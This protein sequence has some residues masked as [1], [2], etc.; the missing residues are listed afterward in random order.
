MSIE[1]R[2]ALNDAERREVYR[3][4]H[5]VYADEGYCE[6]KPGGELRH[7]PYLD[8]IPETT[9][10]IAT[11]R[12]LVVGTVSVTLDGPAGL[13]TDEDFP[14]EMREIRGYCERFG[15]RLAS[16]WRIVTD[17]LYRGRRSLVN[18]LI[19]ETFRTALRLCVDLLV[20]DF[21][22]KHERFYRR[23]VGF[24][25][26]AFANCRAVGNRPAVLMTYDV[27]V[28]KVPRRW[29]TKPC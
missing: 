18:R 17:P 23:V 8:E 26:V 27:D 10:L 15:R 2:E 24:D 7:Y 11:E 29:R 20:C 1:V 9:I 16:S 5:R 13:H 4:T 25:T 6:L 14:R 22:P 12:S 28:K 21:H 19:G 3:L